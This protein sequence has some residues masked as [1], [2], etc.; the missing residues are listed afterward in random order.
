V[1]NAFRFAFRAPLR[2][3]VAATLESE[4]EEKFDRDRQNSHRQD[5]GPPPW[6]AGAWQAMCTGP[7]NQP[8]SLDAEQHAARS[9][10]AVGLA[11]IPECWTVKAHFEGHRAPKRLEVFA[12]C[13]VFNFKTGREKVGW[14]SHTTTFYQLLIKREVAPRNQRGHACLQVGS[15]YT[16]GRRRPLECN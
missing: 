9:V 6:V 3:A 5:R 10:P 16:H 12:H 13:P 4:M 2:L 11:G 1:W 14:V 15:P 8:R 7:C